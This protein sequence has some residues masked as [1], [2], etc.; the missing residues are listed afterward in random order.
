[1]KRQL[2][3]SRNKIDRLVAVK[4]EAQRKKNRFQIVGK[5]DVDDY[6]S[7][8]SIMQPT[9]SPLL[10]LTPQVRQS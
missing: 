10:T 4:N 9:L 3:I 1:M 6:N 8:Q 7:I 5:E 2:G